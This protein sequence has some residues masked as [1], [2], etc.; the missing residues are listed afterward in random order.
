ME[1][2]ERARLLAI[3]RGALARA[4]ERGEESAET[5]AE[6][7]LPGSDLLAVDRGAFVS[8]HRRSDGAIRGCVG[9][10]SSSRPLAEVVAEMAGAAALRDPRFRPV[11]KEELEDVDIEISVLDP[12][13]SCASFD[14]VEIGR[15]GLLV[16]GRGRRGVLLP[17]VAEERG[18]DAETFA[19]QTC[20]K[21]GLEPEDA[22]AADVQFY[23]FRAEVFSESSEGLLSS[24]PA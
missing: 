14:D 18:W 15:D 6:G 5:G 24:V 21:A 17:Q 9:S 20:T 22:H 4:V 7:L 23:R 3:A 13:A 16:I 2:E 8:L 12:P 11:S 1:H 10:M 19:E